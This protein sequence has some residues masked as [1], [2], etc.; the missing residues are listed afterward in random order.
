MATKARTLTPGRGVV[1]GP[2]LDQ[3]WPK[4][5]L[6][7]EQ[8]GIRVEHWLSQ[9]WADLLGRDEGPLTFRLIVQPLVA[10]FFAI[11][12]G[13]RDAREGKPLFF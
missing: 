10:I 1:S 9:N 8:K 4:D 6:G 13:L 11:R 2:L 7:R 12:S 5:L 3:A